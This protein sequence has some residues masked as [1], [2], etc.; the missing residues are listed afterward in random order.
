[1]HVNFVYCAVVLLYFSILDCP[2]ELIIRADELVSNTDNV[3]VN[4]SW[5]SLAFAE[6]YTVTVDGETFYTS[7]THIIAT[8]QY[9][10]SYSVTIL[11]SN[12]CN[13]Q[14]RRFKDNIEITKLPQKEEL[15]EER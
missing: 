15:G 11:A 7:E 12:R 6:Q 10:T 13:Q 3:T 14:C 8:L 5:N 2:P 1:M 9:S 4:M